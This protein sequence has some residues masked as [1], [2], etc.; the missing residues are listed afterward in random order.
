MVAVAIVTFLAKRLIAVGALLL[1]VSLLVFS[2]L[3]LSPG[4]IVATLVGTRP[5]TPELIASIEA[6]YHVNDPFLAQYWHWLAGAVHGDFGRSIQ[7]GQPVT[8]M[9]ADRLPVTLGLAGYA[10]LLVVAI[11]I[12]AGMAAGMRRG[13]AFDR[14]VSTAAVVGMSAPPF[15]VGILLAYVFGV[16]L[17]LFPVYGAGEGIAER[18]QHLTL[19]AFALATILLALIIRQTRAATLD[20]M[21]Q[22]YITF[23]R[24]RGLSRPRILVS[25]A[26]RNTALPI[27]T[28]A[29]LLLIVAVSGAVLVET[30]F[31]LQG[32]GLLMI[33]SITGKDIPVVQGVAFIIA[34]FVTA[35]NL[36]VDLLSL[37]INPRTRYPVEA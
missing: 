2:L 7:S 19:P 25:Y 11:G 21:E 28:V 27:V 23:A 34:I 35:V 30:V 8:A 20:V 9:I 1:V 13:R 17:D 32:I 33:D 22:D 12:P 37:V 15:A 29:G 31:S 4:S 18:I 36:V 6:E 5:T 26:L 10:L 24:A 16:T 14:A 3:A